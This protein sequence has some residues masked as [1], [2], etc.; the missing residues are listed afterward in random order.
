M[1][2]RTAV[3]IKRPVEEVY[4]FWRD[5]TNLPSFMYHLQSVE[6]AGDGRS[7]WTARAPAGTTV[8][9]DAEITEDRPNARIAWAS[10]EGSKVGNSG[11]VAFTQAPGGDGTEVRVE[12]SYDPP[13]GA[14]GK[15][16]AKLFGEEPQQQISD[17]LRRLKQVLETGE[18]V[19]SEGSPEGTRTARL[20]KQR[21]AEPVR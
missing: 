2:A 21:P 14:L 20:L 19:L 11:S 5:F 3:T 1:Q 15:V 13:G 7:H 17:D 8:D 10:V 18:V 12:L 6:P 4:A 9:W 16:A